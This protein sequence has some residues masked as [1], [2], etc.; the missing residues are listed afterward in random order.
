M[1]AIMAKLNGVRVLVTAVWTGQLSLEQ[2]AAFAA[3]FD[4]F[5]ILSLTPGTLHGHLRGDDDI[6]YDHHLRM[7][8]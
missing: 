8:S 3:E 6:V 2:L 1:A 4:A 7:S 5:G